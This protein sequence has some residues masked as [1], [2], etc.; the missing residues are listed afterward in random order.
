MEPQSM[1]SIYITLT[2]DLVSHL[3]YNLVTF[4]YV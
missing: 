4:P 3:K 1:F 2:Y